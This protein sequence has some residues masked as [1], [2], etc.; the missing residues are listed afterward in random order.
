MLD[1]AKAAVKKILRRY[2]QWRNVAHIKA[3]ATPI[4][5]AQLKAGF[6]SLGLKAGDVVMLH[7]SLRSLGYVEGGPTV[8]IEAL[9]EAISPEGTLIVPTYYQPG[10]SI[11]ATC[12]MEGYFFDPRIHGTGLGALPAAFLKFPGVERSIHPTHSVSA[13]GPQARF[14][15]ESHHLAPSIFGEGSPWQRCVEL[16]GKILG[17]GITMGPV[18]FYHL[19]EDMLLDDFP[20][21]V[22]MKESYNIPCKD[23][24]GRDLIVRVAPLDPEYAKRR[25]D[26]PGRSDL[27]DYFWREFNAAGLL[28][29]G[30]V[31]EADSW[32]VPAKSFYDHLHQLMKMGITIYSTPEELLR[33]PIQDS[34][35]TKN[36]S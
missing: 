13:V 15:T 19:L 34:T 11:L 21:P 1:I 27:R 31:G 2:Q 33:R 3:T 14:I 25:I 6:A 32:V 30:K 8:V 29:T 20:L 26:T 4:T 10:G 7:S 9:Y 5:K 18:T 16:E 36:R 35:V 24:S 17:L 23:W 22:R 28:I 12:K